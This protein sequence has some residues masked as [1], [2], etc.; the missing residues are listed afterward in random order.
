MVYFLHLQ[1]LTF[2]ILLI[3]IQDGLIFSLSLLIYATLMSSKTQNIARRINTFFQELWVPIESLFLSSGSLSVL[4]EVEKVL[5]KTLSALSIGIQMP[6]LCTSV[7][8]R[9]TAL[10]FWLAACSGSTWYSPSLSHCKSFWL[11]RV[12]FSSTPIVPC[13]LVQWSPS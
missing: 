8:E 1:S 9:V 10:G 11:A 5:L 2:R 12:C 7:C 6:G 4:G 3:P 13:P